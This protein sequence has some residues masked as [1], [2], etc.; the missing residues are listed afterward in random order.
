MNK[1]A[2][3]VKA[4]TPAI[5]DVGAA[6]VTP[7]DP[8]APESVALTK[9][10]SAALAAITGD[11]GKSSFDPADV[12]GENARFVIAHNAA[13]HA[14]GCG[15]FRPLQPGIA[16]IKRMYS[17][18]GNPGTGSAILSFLEREA[19]AL[20]YHALWLETRL[21]NRRA[22]EFYER[23]GYARIANFGKYVGNPAAVCFEKRLIKTTCPY[24]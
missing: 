10:L 1:E 4:D 2:T 8:T 22:V 14:I 5:E 17:R 13:G 12:R 19:V 9:E 7:T 18:P 6:T 21:V 24:S 23:R 11:S 16:E 15:A 3:I 20:G